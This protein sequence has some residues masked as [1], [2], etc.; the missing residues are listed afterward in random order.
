MHEKGL[1]IR[2]IG[3][4]HNL[5]LN[6]ILYFFWKQWF[7]VNIASSQSIYMHLLKLCYTKASEIFIWKSIYVKKNTFIV[8]LAQRQLHAT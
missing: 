8:V 3:Y 4:K 1:N 2:A 7:Q 5:V 6:L